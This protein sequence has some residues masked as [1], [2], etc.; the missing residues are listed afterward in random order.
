MNALPLFQIVPAL[1]GAAHQRDVIGMLIVGFANDARVAMRT[2]AIVAKRKLLE[3]ENAPA[4]TRQFAGRRRTH[5]ADANHD[6]IEVLLSHCLFSSDRFAAM[7]SG[8]R[9]D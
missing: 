7:G 8:A 1:E 5:A 2:A 3:S 6:Y 4:A 9:E